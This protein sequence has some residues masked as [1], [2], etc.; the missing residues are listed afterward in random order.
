MGA[1]LLCGLLG[2]L[3]IV[4]NVFVIVAL[5]RNR[6]R[7]LRN[8]FYVLVFHCSLVDVIRGGC[9]ISWGMPHLLIGYM[10]TMDARLMALKFNQFTLVILR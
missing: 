5:M 9:L 2:A 10:H 3:S 8:V 7:V 6:R 1:V 4:L